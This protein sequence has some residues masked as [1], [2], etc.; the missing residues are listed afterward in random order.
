MCGLMVAT[1]LDVDVVHDGDVYHSPMRRTVDALQVTT[2]QE[3]L[4]LKD[5]TA[6]RG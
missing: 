2:L 4:H 1:L 3:T 6:L 5:V